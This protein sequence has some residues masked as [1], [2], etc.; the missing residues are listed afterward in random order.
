MRWFP[1]GAAARTLSVP[2]EENGDAARTAGSAR[3]ISRRRARAWSGTGHMPT[4]PSRNGSACGPL[5][6]LA[7]SQRGDTLACLHLE[8]NFALVELKGYLRHLE[9]RVI[10]AGPPAHRIGRGI[11]IGKGKCLEGPLRHVQQPG[12]QRGIVGGWQPEMP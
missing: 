7:L 2:V 8:H 12:P 5:P 3:P 4:C 11:T 1:V 9:Q 10:L 6:F